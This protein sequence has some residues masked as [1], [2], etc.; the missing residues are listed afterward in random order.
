MTDQTSENLAAIDGVIN[1]LYDIR[2]FL[3][4]RR[5][6]S[7][8]GTDPMHA[9]DFTEGALLERALSELLSGLVLSVQG[10]DRLFRRAVDLVEASDTSEAVRDL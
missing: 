8:T 1:T 4:T 6:I 5:V 7:R 2:D 3:R 9:R 10:I